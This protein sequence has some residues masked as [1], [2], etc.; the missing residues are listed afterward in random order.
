MDLTIVSISNQRPENNGNQDY[1]VVHVS[2]RIVLYFCCLEPRVWR[3]NLCLPKAWTVIALYWALEA[4]YCQR[5]HGSQAELR[6][7]N[8]GQNRPP[9]EIL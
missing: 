9:A 5:I 6:G 4:R 8:F 3:G 1:L 2:Y 7:P